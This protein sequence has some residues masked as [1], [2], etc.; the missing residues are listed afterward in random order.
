[1]RAIVLA[2]AMLLG[3]SISHATAQP[4]PGAP[5]TVRIFALK[6]AD[7][8]KL[9]SIITTIFGQQGITATVDAR[10]NSLIVAGDAMT[11]EEIRKLVTKLDEPTK[12]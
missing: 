5:Q 11:L 4:V 6:N 8:E 12:K 10:T 2:F 3:G 1:M 7:A 9:R